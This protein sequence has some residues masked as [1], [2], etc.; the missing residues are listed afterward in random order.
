MIVV[1]GK[2]LWF[3]YC[4]IYIWFKVLYNVWKICLMLSYKDIICYIN[5]IE[6]NLC[7][8]V[9]KYILIWKIFIK[10]MCVNVFIIKKL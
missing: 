6:K 1:W 4:I 2:S 5:K 3:K 7:K 9:Y 8:C 10:N